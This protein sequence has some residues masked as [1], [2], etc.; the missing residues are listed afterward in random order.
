MVGE[1][2]NVRPPRTTLTVPPAAAG[3]GDAGAAEADGA[4]DAGTDAC[5]NTAK[6]A[7]GAGAEPEGGVGDG[8]ASCNDGLGDAAADGASGVG[9]AGAAEGTDADA[10][11]VGNVATAGVPEVDDDGTLADTAPP[12]GAGDGTG[13]GAALD[14]EDADEE[15]ARDDEY[16]GKAADAESGDD[17]RWSVGERPAA[18]HAASRPSTH[19]SRCSGDSAS[20]SSVRDVACTSQPLSFRSSLPRLFVWN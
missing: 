10:P 12:A 18:R 9:A 14:D 1:E 6:R 20:K 13:A 11:L 16:M 8:R 7:V 3:T 5:G 19:W 4:D 17:G 2:W 15:E